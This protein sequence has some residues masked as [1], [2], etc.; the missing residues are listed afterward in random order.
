MYQRVNNKEEGYICH[1]K[2]YYQIS[3]N[4]FS[5]Y[6]PP[7]GQSEVEDQYVLCSSLISPQPQGVYVGGKVQWGDAEHKSF[8]VNTGS[9]LTGDNGVIYFK[10]VDRS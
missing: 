4:K 6:R 9:N 2:N 10:L 5:P 7:P 1:V 8:S 3:F